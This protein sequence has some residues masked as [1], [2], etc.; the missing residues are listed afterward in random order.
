MTDLKGYRIANVGMPAE[1]FCKQ[2]SVDWSTP[3]AI[4]ASESDAVEEAAEKP[5]YLYAISRDHGNAAKTDTIVYIG[6]TNNLNTRFNLHPRYDRAKAMR[7]QAYLSVGTIDF[8]T[9]RTATTKN[10]PALEELEHLFIW[11]LW[12]TLWNEKK[13]W[14]VPGTGAGG[15]RPWQIKNEGYRFAG[16]M[17]RE[18]VYPWLLIKPGRDRSSKPSKPLTSSPEENHLE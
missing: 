16:R 14:N 11:A 12:P 7:G 13:M 8:G 4:K 3:R 10:R 15:L 2:A 5:G 18:I 9:Y 17:P 6:I 1:A